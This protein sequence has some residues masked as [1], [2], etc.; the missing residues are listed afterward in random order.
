MTM[1]RASTRWGKYKKRG[2]NHAGQA[3]NRDEARRVAI[4]RAADEALTNLGSPPVAEEEPESVVEPP[5]AIYDVVG[6]RQTIVWMWKQLGAPPPEQWNCH[7]GPLR[8]IADWLRQDEHSDL[9]PIRRTLERHIACEPLSTHCAG[10][11]RKPKLPHGQQLIA[12]DCLRRGTG[13]EQA[14][15]ILTAWRESKGMSK[16]AAAV[17]RR[18]VQTAVVRLGGVRKRRGTT[19]TGSRDP[20][21][22][23]ATSRDAQAKQWKEQI[24]TPEETAAASAPGPSFRV[25]GKQVSTL[26]KDPLS[27]LG[28]GVI[29]K[30]LGSTWPGQSKADRKRR[31]DS[32]IVGYTEGYT[33][34]NGDEE[35]AYIIRCEGHCYPMRVDDI[36]KLL[37]PALR[38]A[39]GA[40]VFGKIPLEAVSWWDEKHKQISIGSHATKHEYLF[41][42]GRDGEHLLQEHGGEL[43]AREP[44]VKAKYTGDGGRFGFGVATKRDDDGKLF[45]HKFKPF[46][47]SSSWL[48]GPKKY[49]AREAAELARVANFTGDGWGE[50]G[51]GVSE[52]TARR[53]G[54]RYQ[55]RYPD[56]WRKELKLACSKTLGAKDAPTLKGYICVTDLMDDIVEQSTAF[57]AD[58]PYH[59][60]GPTPFVLFHDALKQWWEPEAQD[61]LLKVHGIGPERQ[62]CIQGDTNDAVAAHY[63]NR[64][65]GDTPEFCPLDNN[66]F[67]DFE[68]A[69]RQNLAYTY[70][71]PHD[72]PEKFLSGTAPQVQRLMLLT[73][74]HD[75][76]VRSE[77]I[78]EDICRFPAALDAIIAA[79]GA[80]VARLDR[81]KGRRQSKP[82][83]PPRIP[84]VE[85]LMLKRFERLD[86]PTPATAP[87]AVPPKKRSRS[88]WH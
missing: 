77:R 37:P 50:D 27:L 56:T 14:A 47:Y 2:T 23:W 54:G 43:Q 31:W 35:A 6:Q 40:S 21:S 1:P 13:Q 82:Y 28:K 84:E 57:F 9:R 30:V 45:G 61:H 33:Y 66:L 38:P 85:E 73:W 87:G 79:Q 8:M 7:G 72:H 62:L 18:A 46:D 78:V 59:A 74:E 11:G 25:D 22:K 55:I 69:M 63:R 83:E 75:G 26:A 44:K 48:C 64:L 60:D 88:V 58:T 39:D 67:A 34:I 68:F 36:V 4:V 5:A 32:K 51:L 3:A 20:E 24:V 52:A 41:P 65:V 29:I 53:P 42:R 49:W 81:R 70:W 16:K 10:Q 12:A 19:S 71:L 76:A 17:S 86:P 15:H 80:K